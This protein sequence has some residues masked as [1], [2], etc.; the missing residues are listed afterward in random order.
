MNRRVLVI[1]RTGQMARALQEI[2][3]DMGFAYEAIGRPEVDLTLPHTL[4]KAIERHRPLIVVNAAAYTAVDLAEREP[5]A[6]NTVNGIA[7]GVLAESC[8]KAAI[9]LIH[10]STDYV[11]DGSARRPYA[12]DHPV[13]PQTVYGSTKATGE[14]EVRKNLREH[15]IVRLAWLYDET[16]RNFLNTILKMAHERDSINVVNDQTGPPT[17]AHDAARALHQIV[18]QIFSGNPIWGTFHLT[19]RGSTTWYSFAG[20]I[21]RQAE[22]FGHPRATIHPVSSAEYP[23]KTRRPAYSVLDTS[24]TEECFGISLPSWEDAL[25]RCIEAKFAQATSSPAIA[26]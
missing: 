6:A 18:Q 15:L 22:R 3:S 7:P 25:A 23:V 11:F 12:V 5:D 20:E 13:N 1:G 2:P 9:P 8:K 10:L 4:A 16:G 17:Y 14:S 26:S 19:N 24:L 21:L